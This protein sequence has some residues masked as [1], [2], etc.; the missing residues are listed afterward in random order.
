MN[1]SLLLSIDLSTTACK[2]VVFDT[3][4]VLVAESYRPMPLF[5]PKPDWLEADAND[6]WRLTVECIHEVLSKVSRERIACVGVCGLMHTLLP[7]D[8]YG[9]PLDR[10]MLWMDQRC[11]LQCKELTPSFTHSAGFIK[12]LI[13]TY[14]SAPKVKWLVENKPAVVKKT[15][16]FLF[17]KDYIRMKLTG[18]F[19]TDP[20]D[21]G[22]SAMFDGS[23]GRWSEDVLKAVGISV[24]KMPPIK[25]SS[26][27]AGYVIPSAS[28]E[29]GL[30]VGTPVI[31]G[32]SDVKSTLLGVDM[33]VPNRTCLYMGTAGWMAKSDD[34]GKVH[35]VGSTATFG[36]SLRWYREFFDNLYDYQA[37]V[38][39]AERVPAGSEG[40]LFFPHL[41]GER[42][43]RYDP[44]ARGTIFGITLLHR[45]E[46][47]ARAI[48]EGNAYLVRQIIESYGADRISDMVAV[49]GVA[50]CNTWL[51]II[52]DVTQKVILKPRVIEATALGTAMLSA[53]GI[54]L[55]DSLDEVT[56]RWVHIQERLLPDQ[57]VSEIY[58]RSYKLYCQIDDALGKFYQEG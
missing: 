42:W 38:C 40:L 16:K 2:A 44:N 55:F 9:A 8:S 37:L 7:V 13:P 45:K 51:Q 54:G 33:S 34:N 19:A 15:Y 6:W 39:L 17:G 23:T 35:W 36:V 21:A 29:T 24:D 32:A 57:S 47:I 11:K 56:K 41:M 4:G 50:K 1:G 22:G 49:G 20:S 48:L 18:E 31:V 58:N 10:A 27:I 53:V 46:H 28:E 5:H 26:E 3:C 43:P 30:K 12:G 52:S 14:Y 25:E